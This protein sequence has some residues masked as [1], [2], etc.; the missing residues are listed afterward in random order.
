[1]AHYRGKSTT[2]SF[3]TVNISGEQRSVSYEETADTLD[4]TTVGA[5]ERTK[6]ASLKDGSFSFEALDSTGDWT[7]AW[8]AV[9][10]GASGV[11]VIMPEGAGSSF[12]TVTFTAVITSRSIEF[13]YDDLA[14]VSISGEVSGAVVETTQPA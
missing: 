12:R 10:P 5:D 1:M 8:E 13:P 7:A 4:D 11:V 2:V 14:K 3:A 9:V 6:I